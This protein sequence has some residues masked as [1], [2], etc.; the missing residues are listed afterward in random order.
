[1]AFDP[2]EGR[3]ITSHKAPPEPS[4]DR[5]AQRLHED[6]VTIAV[7]R[8]WWC[9]IMPLVA[10]GLSLFN[11]FVIARK[12]GFNEVVFITF[13]VIMFVAVF[14]VGV[15]FWFLLRTVWSWWKLKR[16]WRLLLPIMLG[17]ALSVVTVP[18]AAQA[19]S[20]ELDFDLFRYV[21]RLIRG[22]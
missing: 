4:P 7:E 2:F 12:F 17:L 14:L 20:L 15:G 11:H 9:W 8:S 1:M 6:A 16:S 13:K 19:I 10:I 22:W 5:R 21:Q 3:V 18:L